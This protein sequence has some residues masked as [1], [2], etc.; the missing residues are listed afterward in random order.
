MA[1][2]LRIVYMNHANRHELFSV[3]VVVKKYMA[4]ASL[5]GG[6]KLPEAMKQSRRG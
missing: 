5:R 1:A 2:C 6:G 4:G 3:R